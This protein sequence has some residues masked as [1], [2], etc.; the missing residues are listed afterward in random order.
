M[1]KKEPPENQ[2][3]TQTLDWF[4]PSLCRA[5][6]SLS[7]S[8]LNR[9]RVCLNCDIFFDHSWTPSVG[10]ADSEDATEVTEVTELQHRSN[11]SVISVCSVAS[12][13]VPI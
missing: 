5:A 4:Q 9:E 2:Q 3:A 11:H 8:V 10:H 13:Y 12:P 1:T 7:I 6:K